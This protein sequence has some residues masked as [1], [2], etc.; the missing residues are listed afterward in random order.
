MPRHHYETEYHS[1]HYT[2]PEL[3]HTY[4]DQHDVE[5][6]HMK[7]HAVHHS[8][9]H[10]DSHSYGSLEREHGYGYEGEYRHQPYHHGE[11]VSYHH[12]EPVYHSA[13]ERHLYEPVHHEQRYYE[14]ERVH[15]NGVSSMLAENDFT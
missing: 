8:F 10:P 1:D 13:V 11:Y 15:H 14:T 5:P 7:E 3:D 6:V 9:D 4:D 2:H 12:E